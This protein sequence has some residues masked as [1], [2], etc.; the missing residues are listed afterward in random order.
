M[1]TVTAYMERL[2]YE[3]GQIDFAQRGGEILR[4]NRE[5]RF[6]DC[7]DELRLRQRLVRRFDAC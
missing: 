7:A 2:P 1:E 3:I 4:G 5:Y 6:N